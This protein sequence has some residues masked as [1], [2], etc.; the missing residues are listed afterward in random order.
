MDKAHI[1]RAIIKCQ[2]SALRQY[3]KDWRLNIRYFTEPEELNPI[4]L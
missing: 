1:K 2:Q 3:L 4:L